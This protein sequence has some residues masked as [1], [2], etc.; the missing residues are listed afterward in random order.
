MEYLLTNKKLDSKQFGQLF[1]EGDFQIQD[2]KL[3]LREGYFTTAKYNSLDFNTIINDKPD[4]IYNFLYYDSDNAQFTVIN[5]KLGKMPVY[6]YLTNKYFCISNQPWKIIRLFQNRIEINDN[7]LKEHLYYFTIPSESATYIDGLKRLPGASIL[8]FNL[9]DFNL[10]VKRY[11]K[12]AYNFSDEKLDRQQALAQFDQD[13]HRLFARIKERHPNSKLGFGNSGGLDSRLVA[14][15]AREH[16]FDLQGYTICNPGSKIGLKS[17]S[18]LNAERIADYFGFQNRII[19][20]K[21]KSYEARMLLDIRNNPFGISQ[22]FKNPLHQIPPFDILVT[23]QQGAMVGD[24]W[25]SYLER[26]DPKFIF[27]YFKFYFERHRDLKNRLMKL[28]GKIIDRDNIYNNSSILDKIV[29]PEKDQLKHYL[30][31]SESIRFVNLYMY[32]YQNILSRYGYNGGF[33]SINRTRPTYYLY[34]PNVFTST[35]KWK[36]EYFYNRSLLKELIA[37]KSPFLA[38][39]RDT[40]LN[41]INGIENIK[42]YLSKKVELALRTTGVNFPEWVKQREYITL[43]RNIISRPNPIFDRLV[44]KDLILQHN[45]YKNMN[46]GGD[47]LKTKKIL[48]IIYYREFNCLDN[49]SFYMK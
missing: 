15:Y 17:V 11:W 18:Y 22:F 20:Y 40:R 42:D 37:D 24:H 33:E 8:K 46:T 29:R 4:G 30:E 19:H 45:L 14:V 9:H 44:N 23:G 34:Y 25:N 35:L 21:P 16:D 12:L 27:K 36:K 10:R 28:I 2:K 38:K 41:K 7:R 5:D 47:F 48:D 39:I 1:Y 32:Y 31:K 49:D 43:Y 26:E 13:L 3:I 6:Y